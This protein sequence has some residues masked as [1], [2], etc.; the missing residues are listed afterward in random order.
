M[1]SPALGPVLRIFRWK[2]S[3]AAGKVPSTSSSSRRMYARSVASK[4]EVEPAGIADMVGN[5]L[6]F[7][8]RFAGWRCSRRRDIPASTHASRCSATRQVLWDF[9]TIK[10]LEGGPWALQTRSG[11]PTRLNASLSRGLPP[12]GIF[13]PEE[14]A[15]RCRTLRLMD[16]P[17]SNRDPGR[18]RCAPES[19]D[20]ASIE[21]FPPEMV[22]IGGAAM[23][24][25]FRQQAESPVEKSH[26]P[27]DP[28]SRAR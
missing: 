23:C 6:F 15:C 8:A 27:T 24:R 20:L 26:T 4:S 18:R 2:P 7:L 13:R 5:R 17:V 14:S 9:S 19:Q 12:P 21:H 16:R 3:D 10:V 1:G 22:R 11:N 25:R 28:S